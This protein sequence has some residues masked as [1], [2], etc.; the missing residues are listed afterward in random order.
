MTNDGVV[1]ERARGS[2]IG[3]PHVCMHSTRGASALRGLADVL[4]E[5]RARVRGMQRMAGRDGCCAADLLLCLEAL[6]LVFE[7]LALLGHALGEGLGLAPSLI[8]QRLH[9]LLGTLD[10]NQREL[11]AHAGQLPLLALLGEASLRGAQHRG[12]DRQLV[13]QLLRGG[14]ARRVRPDHCRG[15][16]ERG[17]RQHRLARSPHRVD[18]G[19]PGI[20]RRGR[21]AR[22]RPPLAGRR[23]G[24]VVRVAVVGRD[25]ARRP[26]ARG[27]DGAVESAHRAVRHPRAHGAGATAVARR[28][29]EGLPRLRRRRHGAPTGA[30]TVPLIGAVDDAGWGDVLDDGLLSQ[31]W[32]RA[33]RPVAVAGRIIARARRQH[34]DLRRA[35][36]VATHAGLA[37]VAPEHGGAPRAQSTEIVGLLSGPRRLLRWLFT[38][39]RPLDLSTSQRAK[40]V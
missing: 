40:G 14:P 13:L 25:R 20:G 10:V 2:A 33:Q 30:R 39:V 19:T 7:L 12:G 18:V 27:H 3:Y 36:V 35:R 22:A 9:L 15:G 5:A 11:F 17:P 29:D 8:G 32:V 16:R 6:Q 23:R 37:H 24:D 31:C 28:G 26:R 21:A 34:D 1:S 4:W 38:V